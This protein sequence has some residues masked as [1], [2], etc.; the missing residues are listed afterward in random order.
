MSKTPWQR[1][2]ASSASSPTPLMPPTLPSE[3]D[4]RRRVKTNVGQTRQNMHTLLLN[5]PETSI[6]KGLDA[7]RHH[8][9]D[10]HRDDA[11]ADDDDAPQ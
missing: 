9:R 8:G 1:Y 10:M 11:V 2:A 5:T 4:A 6:A 3:L 7:K